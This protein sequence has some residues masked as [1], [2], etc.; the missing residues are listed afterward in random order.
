[1]HLFRHRSES[2]ATDFRLVVGLGNP[3]GQY[4]R[5]RHNAGYMVAN[6][7]ARRMGVSFRGSRQHA[8]LAR[9]SLAGMPVMTALP[10]T[11]MNNS[12]E[13][14]TRLLSYYHIPLEHL[15][16]I[17]DDLDLPFGTIRLRTDGSSGGNG[18]LKSIIRELG[19]GDFTR[20]R[21]GIGRPPGDAINYVLGPFPPDQ[22]ALLPRLVAI[23]ADAVEA[24][25]REGPRAAMNEFNRDWLPEISTGS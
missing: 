6:E 25:L 10:T 21:F 8:D 14:V 7:I 23:A 3:G 15:L 9:G 18:G 12:G 13:A 22:T 5:T 2:D 24:S 20:L 17:A 19:T 4:E 16:V 11:F 1:M